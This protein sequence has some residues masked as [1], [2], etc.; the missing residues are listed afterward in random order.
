MRLLDFF[1]IAVVIL[2]LAIF[3][4]GIISLSEVVTVRNE[5]TRLPE[6]TVIDLGNC[7]WDSL[8]LPM[9]EYLSRNFKRTKLNRDDLG[10]LYTYYKKLYVEYTEPVSLK[11]MEAR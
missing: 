6:G 1:V 10:Q 11:T 3:V 2:L 9:R 5:L 8:P 7:T 4:M